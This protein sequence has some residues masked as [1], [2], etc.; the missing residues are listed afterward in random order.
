MS[1]RHGDTPYITME[2]MDEKSL[3][4]VLDTRTP[5]S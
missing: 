4:D 2:F 5:R 1:G 3:G